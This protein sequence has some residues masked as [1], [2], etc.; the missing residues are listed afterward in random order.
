[1]NDGLDDISC[2]LNPV[3]LLLY[4]LIYLRL[5]FFLLDLDGKHG[6]NRTVNHDIKGCQHSV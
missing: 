3:F 6:L 4:L 2:K 5:P 1:M